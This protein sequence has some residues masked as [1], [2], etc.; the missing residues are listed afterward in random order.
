LVI[1]M[2]VSSMAAQL[3]VERRIDRRLDRRAESGNPQAAARLNDRATVDPNAWRMRYNNNQWWYYTPKNSWMYYD[4]NTWNAYDA[5]TYLPPRTGY[6][7][8]NQAPGSRGRYYTGYRGY[9]GPPASA[10][11]APPA[12]PAPVPVPAP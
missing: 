4:N 8:G 12:V 9:W 7:Y 1:L 5:K 2:A 10:P 11:V 3:G 6:V